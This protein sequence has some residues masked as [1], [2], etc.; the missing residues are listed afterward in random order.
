MRT[1]LSVLALTVMLTGGA[2]VG[3]TPWLVQMHQDAMEDTNVMVAITKNSN[4]SE[5]S[6]RCEGNKDIIAV[7]KVRRFDRSIKSLRDVKWR[8]D[9]GPVFK[10]TWLGI[11]PGLFN[12]VYARR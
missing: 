1:L 11:D 3:P 2:L 12:A 9:S 8:I 6:V 10:S 4:G 5:A 7:V